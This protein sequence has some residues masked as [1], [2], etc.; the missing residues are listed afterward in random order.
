D[1]SLLLPLGISSTTIG[2]GLLLAFGRP[3]VDLRGSWWIVPIAQAMVALPLVVR[4]VLP[5][6]RAVP[7]SLLD[8]AALLGA[9]PSQ[10][11]WRVELPLVRRSLAAGAALAMVACL[12][13]FGATVFLARSTRPTVPVAIERLMSRPGGAGYGQAMAL[14]CVLVLLCAA[15]VVLLDRLLDR[16]GSGG[17]LAF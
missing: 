9:S 6:M 15:V 17:D 10:R 14:S 7:A 16:D 1:R 4:A 11:W 12:G 5:G 8:T 13:E 2:L 3:P